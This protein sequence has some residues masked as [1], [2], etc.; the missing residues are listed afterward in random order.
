MIIDTQAH[1][2][3]KAEKRLADHVEELIAQEVDQSPNLHRCYKLFGL[4]RYF[5]AVIDSPVLHCQSR[6]LGW[7]PLVARLNAGST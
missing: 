7:S 5:P 6:Q 2:K 4:L 1:T 3:S